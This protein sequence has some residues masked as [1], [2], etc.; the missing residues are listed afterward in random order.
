MSITRQVMKFLLPLT[1]ESLG[2]DDLSGRAIVP[3]YVNPENFSIQDNK[4]ISESLTKGGFIVQY[5]GEQLGEIQASGTTGSG[6]I[7]A[8][9]ILR[10]VYRNEITQFNNILLERAF[11]LDQ[12]ARTA[13]EDTST[14]NIGA[15]ISSIFDEITQG[16]FSN[17]IDGTKSAIEEITQAAKGITDNNPTSVELIP[18]IGAFATN[19]ILY[20]Q[21]EKFTGYFKSFRVDE[22]AQ[23]PGIFSYQFTF[24]ITKRSGIRKNFM[25]WHRNPY[26]SSGEP[27]TAS[28]PIEGQNLGELTFPTQSSTFRGQ[29]N[30]QN[31]RNPNSI[32]SQ[33]TRNQ[34]SSQNDINRVNTNRNNFI[35]GK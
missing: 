19:M 10:G 21:G 25:A 8:I 1:V 27:R 20:W 12:T 29:E 26:D 11:L 35:R 31:Q 2:R 9:N 23:N 33:F 32:T 16:G 6:G 30:L 4:I 3:L 24:M 17:I 13:L 7:E 5:W 18:T 34:R 14:A 15:G 28:L 22:V